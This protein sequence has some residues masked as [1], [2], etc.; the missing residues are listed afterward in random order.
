MV[1]SLIVGSGTATLPVLQT[2]EPME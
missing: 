1:H 2:A